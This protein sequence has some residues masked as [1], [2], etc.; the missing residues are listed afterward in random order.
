[1]V[2]VIFASKTAWRS[3]KLTC[4]AYD[5]DKPTMPAER[6]VPEATAIIEN[7]AAPNIMT[8]PIISNRTASH[9]NRDSS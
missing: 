1:M 5:I 2:A 6:L 8:E 4:S 3:S 7:P 9:L